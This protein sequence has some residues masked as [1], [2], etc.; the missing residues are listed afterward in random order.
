MGVGRMYK[1]YAG[2]PDYD[3]VY[4]AVMRSGVV[5]P[6]T[7]SHALHALGFQQSYAVEFSTIV[8]EPYDL[9]QIVRRYPETSLRSEDSSIGSGPV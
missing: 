8:K 7:S 5:F 2:F 1:R 6:S 3:I 9:R 4:I